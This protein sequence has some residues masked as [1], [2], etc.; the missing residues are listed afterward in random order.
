MQYDFFKGMDI[1]FLDEIETEGGSF[2]ENNSK[3]DMID[4]LKRN[5]VN[6]I[7]LRIWNDPPGGYC[8]LE[9]TKMMAKR[10]KEAGL[11]F[12][13]DFHYSDSWADPAKQFKP[14]AWEGLCFSDLVQ[15]VNDYTRN[16]IQELKQQ[17]T[18]PNMVQIGNEI[19]PGM[20]WDDG[21]VSEKGGEFDLDSQWNNLAELIQSG[22][23]GLNEA[24][25]DE[26]VDIMLHID[27]GGDHEASRYFYDKMERLG[28]KFDIIGLS[29]YPWW[30]GTLQQLEENIT[31]LSLRYKKEIIVVET[32]YP[33][34]FTTKEGY[35]NMV[36]SED[37]LHS[38]YSAS[39]EGQA[40][41]LKD[42][43]NLI[44]KAGNGHGRGLYYWE[45]C[46]IPSKKEWSVGHE[47][48]WG[49]LALFD[50]E[51]NKLDSLDVFK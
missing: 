21:R 37:Q 50:F 10:I 20:L 43:M 45:P 9:R 39:V 28:I 5:G 51:G 2:Y 27:R 3:V 18:L 7:R 49:N 16:V 34:T 8:N 30:H 26:K 12:L 38:G 35:Q 40:N 19:T 4:L 48:G 17:D 23:S 25:E 41:Y 32:A 42:I 36:D 44:Q 13:L 15:A 11:H 1:S 31:G 46:W 29:Y 6:S 33:W 22:I 47:N 14:K 24:L